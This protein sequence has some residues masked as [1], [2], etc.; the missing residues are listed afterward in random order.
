[1]YLK[2]MIKK[3]VNWLELAQDEDQRMA[4]VNMVMEGNFLIS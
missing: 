1:M 4:G 2:N 3:S